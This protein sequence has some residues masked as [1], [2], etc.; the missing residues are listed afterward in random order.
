[1]I[2]LM[3]VAGRQSAKLAEHLKQNRGI[4][5]RLCVPFPQ[6]QNQEKKIKIP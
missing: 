4:Q 6:V 3:I 1:M 5:G 2:K